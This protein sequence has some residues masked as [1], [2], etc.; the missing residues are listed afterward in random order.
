MSSKVYVIF[1]DD[2]Q[3]WWSKFLKKGIRHCYI[4]KPTPNSFIIYGKS[5]KNV[6]LFTVIDQKSIIEGKYIMKSYIPRE[7]RRSLFMLNTCVG[8]TKQILGIN[9]PFIL[10][11]YQLLKHLRS[12]HEA[13]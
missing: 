1:E 8:H 13:A 4:V 9:N 2:Q 5:V 12:H 7:C 10:T 11:P 3:R 6:D